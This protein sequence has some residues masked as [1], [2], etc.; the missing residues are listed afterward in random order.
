M[1]DLVQWG[2]LDGYELDEHGEKVTNPCPSARRQ[3]VLT[4][5]YCQIAEQ[6]GHLAAMSVA[7]MTPSFGIR[8]PDVVW[9]PP[10]QWEGFDRDDPVPFVPDLCVEVLLDSARSLDIDR[11][12]SAYLD[13]GAR[14]VIVIS[15]SGQVQFWGETGQRDVSAFGVTL[16]LDSLYFDVGASSPQAVR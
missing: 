14:E 1:T 10:E 5:A 6:M 2:R 8:M 12:V 11:R 9:M 3:I 15:Q 16:L 13:G 7:V 4:D